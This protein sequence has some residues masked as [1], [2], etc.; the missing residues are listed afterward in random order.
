MDRPDLL[1]QLADLDLEHGLLEHTLHVTRQRLESIV[2]DID[3]VTRQLFGKFLAEMTD[4]DWKN[5]YCEA[6]DAEVFGTM[7]GL[8]EVELSEEGMPNV[9]SLHT[10]KRLSEDDIPSAPDDGVCEA[11]GAHDDPGQTCGGCRGTTV[12]VPA[13]SGARALP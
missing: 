13:T 9:Q 6:E 10:Q 2:Y 3:S 11:C 8:E 12:V 7:A 1:K 4:E 5:F